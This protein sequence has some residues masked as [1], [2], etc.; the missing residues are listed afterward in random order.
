MFFMKFYIV[1]ICKF[2]FKPDFNF[3][4]LSSKFLPKSLPKSLPKAFSLIELSIV[5]LIASILITG[6]LSF[7]TAGVNNARLKSTRERIDALYKSLANYVLVNKK[8]PCPAS[9]MVVKSLDPVNYGLAVG[10]DGSCSG[11]G[12]YNNAASANPNVV[13]GMVP[14]KTLGLS[15]DMGEDGFENK[16]VY[17][18]DNRFTKIDT[19]LQTGFGLT[20][21]GSHIIIEEKSAAASA[22]DTS[23]AIF[24]LISYGPNKYG[25]FNANSNVQ[26]SISLDI[27]ERDNINDNANLFSSGVNF[28]NII[29]VSSNASDVFDD[30]VLYKTR[31]QMIIDFNAFNLILCPE[32]NSGIDLYVVNGSNITWPQGYYNQIVIANN[33]CPTGYLG[34]TTIPTKRCEAFGVWGPVI[35]PCIPK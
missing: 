31:N 13:Y 29:V 27:D 7:S 9:L 20:I 28:D 33:N 6:A 23:A 3:K 2:I 5:I 8:L 22:I 24:A 11:A 16:I 32:V 1:K 21:I 4:K 35:N 17:I 30:I 18:I 26:N 19:P 12:V 25:A 15:N 10:A 34:G 14:I